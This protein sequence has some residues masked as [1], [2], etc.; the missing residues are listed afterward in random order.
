MRRIFTLALGL[1]VGLYVGATVV[2][3]IE[4]TKQAVRPTAVAGRAGHA[5]GSFTTRVREAVVE[6]REAAV[7]REAELRARFDVP[8][9][10]AAAPR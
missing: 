4:R 1:G 5:A 9:L 6:G 2:R 3:L 10:Q 7:K 8:G